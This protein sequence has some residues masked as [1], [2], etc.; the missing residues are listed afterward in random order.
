MTQSQ[1]TAYV[2]P[3]GGTIAEREPPQASEGLLAWARANLFGNLTDTLITVF[4]AVFL[5]WAAWSAFSSFVLRANVAGVTQG[6]GTM[7][8]VVAELDQELD[9]AEAMEA[10]AAANATALI[11]EQQRDLADLARRISVIDVTALETETR[12]GLTRRVLPA[13]I[14]ARFT[15]AQSKLPLSRVL[16]L[17]ILKRQLIDPT[18]QSMPDLT[19]LSLNAA[20]EAALARGSAPWHRGNEVEKALFR[21]TLLAARRII[22]Q[23]VNS[24]GGKFYRPIS[25]VRRDLEALLGDLRIEGALVEAS[26][27]LER[28]TRPA[29][30]FNALVD[31]VIGT[32]MTTIPVSRLQKIRKDSLTSDEINDLRSRVAAALVDEAQ[33]GLSPLRRSKAIED[34]RAALSDSFLFLSRDM[35]GGYVDPLPDKLLNALDAVEFWPAAQILA[36]PRRFLAE[37]EATD[38]GSSQA[39]GSDRNPTSATSSDGL[40]TFQKVPLVLE[41]MAQ[42]G[43]PEGAYADMILQMAVAYEGQDLAA[44]RS[45]LESLDPAVDWARSHNGA[46]WAVINQN[47]WPRMIVGTYPSEK[48]WRVALVLLGLVVAVAPLLVPACRTRPFFVFAGIYP[49]FLLFMLSGLAL[50]FY[51]FHGAEEGAGL[52]S[53]LYSEQ[54]R[55]FQAVLMLGLILVA[56]FVRT[57][58]AFGKTAGPAL[59]VAQ[60]LA[61]GYFVIMIWGTIINPEAAQKNILVNSNFVGLLTADHPLGKEIDPANVQAEIDA[62]VA[63]ANESGLKRREIIA[64][65]TQA[66]ALRPE[67]TA[68]TSA[69]RDFNNVVAEGRGTFVILPHVPSLGWGGLLVTMV[70]GIIGMAASLPIGIVLAFGR[71]STLPVVRWFSTG[72][73]EVIRGVPL[74]ALLLIVT[75]VLP[76]LLPPGTE[77]PKLGLVLL[78]ICLFGG[79]YQAEVIRG[80]LQSLPKGQVEAA[81]AMG[82]TFW[83]ESRLITLPQA[84]KAVIPAIVNTFIGLFKDTTLVIVVGI[85]D[86]LTIVELQITAENAWNTTKPEALIVVSLI[87]FSLMFSL[88][89]YSILLEKRLATGHR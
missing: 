51:G 28:P 72:L 41:A 10:A 54:G 44:M 68:A 86:L 78:A 29:L 75:F 22:G 55:V 79:V 20:E 43:V 59:L 12:L 84:L 25:E 4:L 76:K 62:L 65:R 23:T 83:Q 32:P 5:T 56:W 89:R 85:V 21:S 16:E 81:Q 57:R 30:Q 26:A 3:E 73:I 66:N 77:Y 27:L 6:E 48:L 14:E 61:A 82:L 2:Q 31:G 64:L 11:T 53:Q 19:V 58:T 71:Q 69:L 47:F 40:T 88:S 49:L 52:P 70:L 13:A 1:I 80:G 7:A 8:R 63:R 60:V 87:F 17:E 33:P 24:D 36:D 74:I 34:T 35:L 39:A 37:V 67:L 18:V 46:N 15:I 45:A 42:T 9:R 50:R 38:A